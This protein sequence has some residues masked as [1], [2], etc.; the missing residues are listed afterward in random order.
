[1]KI[2]FPDRCTWPSEKCKTVAD[3]IEK[4]VI[5]LVGDKKSGSIAELVFRR[6]KG[7]VGSL[8]ESKGKSKIIVLDESYLYNLTELGTGRGDFD[9]TI[10]ELLK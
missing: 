6:L 1:M 4:R 8:I 9:C 5:L 2:I 7:D 10:L 3:L